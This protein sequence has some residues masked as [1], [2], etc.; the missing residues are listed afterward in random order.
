M[1]LSALAPIHKSLTLDCNVE[2]AFRRFTDGLSTWWPLTTHSVIGEDTE[3]IG[4][5]EG[6][7]IERSRSGAEAIWGDVLVWESPHRVAL[8]WHPGHPDSEATE[9]EVQFAPS[10]EGTSVEYRGWERIGERGAEERQNHDEAWE[11]VLALYAR[12]GM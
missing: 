8:T 2:D 10:D 9:V 4:F 7:L 5:T 12:S 6:R 11:T 1:S 3:W